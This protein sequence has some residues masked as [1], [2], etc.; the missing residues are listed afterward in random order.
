MAEPLN[1]MT[2][3][4]PTPVPN[5]PDDGQRQ[6]FGGHSGSQCSLDADV[7]GFGSLLQQAL[8]GQHM[9]HLAGADAK[10]QGSQRTMRGGVRIS[11]HD[12]H[13]WQRQSLLWPDDMYNAL[14]SVCYII[15][16]ETKFSG[17]LLHRGQALKAIFIHNI[18]HTPAWDG[19]HIMIKHADSSIGPMHRATSK[20]Q[21]SKSLW[22]SHLV[23]E[24][25]IDVQ[26]GG[27]SRDITY[28]VCFPDLL[29][30]SLW[31]SLLLF[32]LGILPWECET[33]HWASI[34]FII[35]HFWNT[36]GVKLTKFWKVG[37]QARIKFAIE[38]KAFAISRNYSTLWMIDRTL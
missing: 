6:V 20:S 24:M 5:L 21:T 8:G 34:S 22:G 9:L 25:S 17:V 19:G 4:V 38:G 37:L 2:W 35:S 15:K 11:T 12:R 31:L 14:A 30:H 18:Q 28:N 33:L 10:G 27:F 7:H 32:H 29:K 23:Y 36:L 3:P 26:N 16:S 1:S 13:S